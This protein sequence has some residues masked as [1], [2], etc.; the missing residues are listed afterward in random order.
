MHVRKRN[1]LDLDVLVGPLVEELH[2]ANLLSDVLGEDG[3]GVSS[4]NFNFAVFRHLDKSLWIRV[5][6]RE[7]WRRIVENGDAR[8]VRIV[9]EGS[10]SGALAAV[11]ASRIGLPES[12][13]VSLFSRQA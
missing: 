4:L 12:A 1:V 6:S 13:Y 10:A 9:R 8:I 7:C 2:G 11:C 5:S 3:V